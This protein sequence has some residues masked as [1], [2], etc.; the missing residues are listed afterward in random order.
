MSNALTLAEVG[1]RLLALY[2]EAIAK[3]DFGEALTY[4][5]PDVIDHRGGTSG[6]HHGIDAWRAKWEAA[7]GG[8]G[9]IHDTEVTVLATVSDGETLANVYSY[10]GVHTATG[11]PFDVGG[12]DL[13]RVRD[14]RVVEHWAFGDYDAIRAQVGA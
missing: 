10:R 8:D 9:E 1:R 2:P 11:K 12:M 6:D 7:A 4:I 14:G 3:G 5:D 13:I